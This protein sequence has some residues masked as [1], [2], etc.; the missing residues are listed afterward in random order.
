MK[1][2]QKYCICYEPVNIRIDMLHMHSTGYQPIG[3]E[4]KT[5]GKRAGTQVREGEFRDGLGD[6][7]GYT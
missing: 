4:S 5:E 6:N 1:N 2:L 3:F 7:W